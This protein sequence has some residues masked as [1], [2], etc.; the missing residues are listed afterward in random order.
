MGVRKGIEQGVERGITQGRLSGEQAAL[1][2]V[3]EGRFGPLPAWVDECIARLTEETEIDAY[4][5]AAATA[6]SLDSLFGQC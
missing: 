2:T 6:D 4:I 3:I 1:K 5:R